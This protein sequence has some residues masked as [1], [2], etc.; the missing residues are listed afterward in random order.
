MMLVTIEFAL[1]SGVEAEFEAAL[2]EAHAC[3]EQYDGF[4]G[5]E[6]C[7]NIDD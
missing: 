4:L 5:E 1:R 7:K 3:L 2:N 6:P